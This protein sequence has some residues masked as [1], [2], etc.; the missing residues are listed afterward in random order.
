MR[1]AQ[2][3]SGLF[4]LGLMIY[5]VSNFAAVTSAIKPGDTWEQPEDETRPLAEAAPEVAT[6]REGMRKLATEALSRVPLCIKR[7]VTDDTARPRGRVLIWD[8]ENDDVSEAHGRLPAEVRLQSIDDPCTVYLITE[9]ERTHVLDYN[10]DF[11]HG[12]GD[13]GVKGFRTDLVVCAVDLPSR[14]PRGRYEIQ[15]HGPPNVVELKPGRKEVDENWAGNLKKW[16]NE[17]VVGTEA[18]YVPSYEQTLYRHADAAR[19]VLGE[20]ELLG[21]LPTLG[22]FPRKATIYNLQTDRLH[23]AHSLLRNRAEAAA[24]S[25]LLVLPLDQTTVIDAQNR[26]GRVNWRVALVAF[27]NAEPLGVYQVQGEGWPIPKRASDTW[28]DE[29]TTNKDDRDPNRAL[30]R[31]VEDL[32]KVKG[33]LPR[34]T[35]AVSASE[36]QLA[37][38][39]WLKGPG[40]LKRAKRPPLPASQQGWEKMAEECS[41]KVKACR[42]LGAAAPPATL[43]K[44]VVVWTDY[45]ETFVPSRAQEKLP[46]ALQAGSSDKAVVMALI[47]GQ[48][49]VQLPKGSTKPKTERWDYELALFTMP[50]ARP[51]GVY[52]AQGET[53]PVDRPRMGKGVR[54][55]DINKDVAAWLTRFMASPDSV[56]AE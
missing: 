11:F 45:A 21:S 55:H 24:E 20:C 33:G 48:Q 2:A 46:S 29:P 32:C 19:K 47:V 53:L 38:T 22:K 37:G 49:L 30:A 52:H 27:P 50:G 28:A 9:R 3:L 56:A 43:P 44:K 18:K 34:S 1:A 6:L 31:W 23:A 26:F 8:V 41:D 4:V 15:G 13:A 36:P 14:Q 5:V 25:R 51:I 42:S 17:C 40:W 7:N 16:I 12:G 10:Y 35:F 54:N 39:D